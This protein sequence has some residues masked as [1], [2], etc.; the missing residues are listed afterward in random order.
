M[1]EFNNYQDFPIA[2]EV[3]DH[4][5]YHQNMPDV[6]FFKGYAAK[7]GGPVLELGC[8]TGRVLLPLARA[9][10][11]VTGL[12]YSNLML[13]ATRAKLDGEPQE[14]QDRVGLVEASMHDFAL[15][16]QFGLIF[17]TYRSF[18]ILI[19]V[20]QQ[21][22]ALE[23]VRR[24]LRDDGRLI[25]G[26]FEPHL[27][28]LIDQGRKEEWGRDDPFLMPDGRKVKVTYRNPD[29]ALTRQTIACELIYTVEHPGGK[30][31]RLVQAFDLHY[32]FRFEMEHLLARTGFEVEELFGDYDKCEFGSKQP[33]E[34]V[35][36]ARKVR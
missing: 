31:E 27:P 11:E 12:D 2:I 35:F 18:Q 30:T 13:R 23:C 20:E 29:V 25:L 26:V 28:F 15:D 21:L 6:E 1:S 9:G 14:V 8:G 3:Y 33:G 5:P 19:T 22:A 10:S 32:Y 7:L 4:I 36:V 34:M 24:H 17:S 16:R